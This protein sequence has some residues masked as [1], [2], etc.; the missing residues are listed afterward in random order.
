MGWGNVREEFRDNPEMYL[1]SSQTFMM[2][3]FFEN[4]LQLKAVNYF[5]KRSPS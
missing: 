1:E 2:D 5:R 4:S 3:L